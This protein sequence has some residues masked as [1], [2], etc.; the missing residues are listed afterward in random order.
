MTTIL[1]TGGAGYIGSHACRAL[2]AA[3]FEPVSYDN[4][5]R[6]NRW[7]VQWGP[8]E[9][10]DIRDGERVGA[11]L[12]RYRPAAVMHFAALAYVGES[13]REPLLYFDNNV[14]GAVCLL[15]NVVRHGGMPVVFSSTCATYG[16]S[17]RLPITEDHPQQPVNPYGFTKLATERL[18]QDLDGAAGLRSVSLRYFNAAGAAPDAA[19]GEA[20][21][22]ETHLIPRV[23]AAA[24]DG[25]DVPVFGD[26]YD[27]PDGTCIRDFVH[28]CDLADAHVRAL[29]Y[30]LNGGA[31]ERFNL[32]NARGYSVMEVIAAA[33]EVCGRPIRRRILPRQ[34][35]DP[36]ALIGSAARAHQVLGWQIARPSLATQIEDA[37][38][39]MEKRPFA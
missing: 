2:A 9:V 34:A 3:G 14:A 31:T 29:T 26:D 12:A 23:L 32:A 38:R 30:L 1:V 10:G 21:E 25:T 5:S 17:Q 6:G 16:L 22:P 4:L 35:G 18:L 24:R 11:V 15:Q 39:W 28:V 27:T 13:M 33:E 20:H 7:A 19:I 37:W 36:A 8:L